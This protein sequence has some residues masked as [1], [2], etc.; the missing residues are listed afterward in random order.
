MAGAGNQAHQQ[1]GA[2]LIGQQFSRRAAGAD[3]QISAFGRLLA[4]LGQIHDLQHG[5]RCANRQ[6]IAIRGHEIQI[7]LARFADHQYHALHAGRSAAQGQQAQQGHGQKATQPEKVG[8]GRHGA[9]GVQADG[10]YRSLPTLSWLRQRSRPERA[11]KKREI[12]SFWHKMPGCPK[13]GKSTLPNR[14]G[15][16]QSAIRSRHAA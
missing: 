8:F 16:D 9:Y 15:C 5:I 6:A 3:Q 10:C 12:K 1:G 4:E 7:R 13:A 2:G 14:A 11:G